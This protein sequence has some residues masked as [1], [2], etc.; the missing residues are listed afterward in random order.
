MAFTFQ[1]KDKLGNL[2]TFQR[3]QTFGASQNG[4]WDQQ[5]GDN[6]INCYFYL[7]SLSLSLF[8]FFFNYL[9]LL[10]YIY[11]SQVVIPFPPSFL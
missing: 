3:G 4:I 11:T 10:F 2:L 1:I 6:S 9:L 8:F 7:V 5:F